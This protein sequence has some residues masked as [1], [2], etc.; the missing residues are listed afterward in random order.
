MEGPIKLTDETFSHAAEAQPGLVVIDFWAPWCGPCRVLGPIVDRLAIRY[1]GRAT[2]VKINV[3]ENPETA[4]RFG[5]R[6]IPALL[7]FND[8]VAVDRTVGVIPELILQ[9]KVEQLLT[10]HA[11]APL[12][13]QLLTSTD[14]L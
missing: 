4:S 14:S 6:S 5:V 10:S 8:G 9:A 13:A 12:V 7:F 3:D 2:F 1:N 11:P